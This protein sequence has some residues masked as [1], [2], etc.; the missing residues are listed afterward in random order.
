MAVVIPG[1]MTGT[2]T[3][4]TLGNGDQLYLL[5]G[6]YLISSSGNTISSGSGSADLFVDGLV[7]GSTAIHLVEIASSPVNYHVEIGTHG[8]IHGRTVAIDIVGD[9]DAGGKATLDNNG[10]ITGDTF[11]LLLYN[12]TTTLVSNSGRI[13]SLENN[14]L[15]NALFVSSDVFNLNNSGTIENYMLDSTSST[16]SNAAIASLTIFGKSSG[17]ITDILNSG[18]ILSAGEAI[19]SEQG[20]DSLINTGL[21]RGNV[22][23]DDATF[24]F[25]DYVDN[26]GD[27]IGDILLGNGEDTVINT[28]KISGDLHFADDSLAPASNDLLEN[29]GAIFGDIFLGRGS[30][31]I[32]NTGTITGDIELGSSG[33]QKI[34]NDGTIIGDIH[35]YE[36]PDGVG[37]SL[38]FRNTGD[39]IGGIEIDG[40]KSVNI[41][42]DGTISGSITIFDGPGF[43]V[44]NG[45]IYSIFFADE[46]STYNGKNGHIVSLFGSDGADTF[47]LDDG[48]N[49]V[50]ASDGGDFM[51]AAGGIDLL[52]YYDSNAGV[53][54]SLAANRGFGGFAQ[55]D[56]MFNFENLEGS[57]GDDK[58]VGDNGAN[59]ITGGFGED[60]LRGQKGNDTLYGGVGRDEL[61]GDNG[62]DILVGGDAQDIMFGGAGGD[63]FLYEALSDSGITGADRDKIGDFEQGFDVFDLSS[64]GATSFDG[65]SFSGSAG[66]VRYIASGGK[67]DILLDVDGD[68]SADFTVRITNGEFTM[69]VDDFVLG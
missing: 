34:Q 48:V 21:I 20:T 53:F 6:E 42:N 14:A 51:D 36:F 57:F 43:V 40:A 33:A 4:V 65:T 8:S 63:V 3:L 61:Y 31:T 49:R 18:S 67:T 45:E 35:T 46:G 17:D 13:S 32:N 60:I 11:G 69:T 12:L 38:L 9:I 15:S 2:S 23:F 5:E 25:G 30:D 22:N 19:E 64:I 52:S 26:S 7:A 66:S 1:S 44:N 16:Y 56:R 54:V 58:L 27:I 55:G 24:S 39:L 10:V 59:T 28:G 29:G 47:Y 68:G 62:E 41:L 50:G 37:R